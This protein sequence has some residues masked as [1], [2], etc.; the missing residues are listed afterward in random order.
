M[1]APL[2]EYCSGAVP[3]HRIN[4]NFF[5]GQAPG[6]GCGRHA[7]NNLLGQIYYV[8]NGQYIPGVHPIPLD[9]LCRALRTSMKSMNA[10][11]GEVWNAA[12]NAEGACQDNENYD[13]TVLIAGL[14]ILGFQ[15]EADRGRNVIDTDRTYGFLIN[16]TTRGYHWVALR[17]VGGGNYRYFDSLNGRHGLS[18]PAGEL[19]TL[20]NFKRTHP[21]YPVFLEV[22]KPEPRICIEPLRNYGI[23]QVVECPFHPGQEIRFEG[24]NYTVVN[25]HMNDAACDYLDVVRSEIYVPRLIAN[26]Q[27][28]FIE[29]DMFLAGTLLKM[30]I[31]GG[32]IVGFISRD[33]V[34]QELKARIG[35]KVASAFQ[36]KNKSGAS[37]KSYTNIIELER[38]VNAAIRGEGA[39]AN[40]NNNNA[41]LAA[42]I[43][44]SLQQTPLEQARAEAARAKAEAEAAEAAAIAAA[45]EA[46][47]RDL[48]RQLEELTRAKAAK[49]NAAAAAAA[50]ERNAAA[51]AAAAKRNAALVA[52]AAA[53]ASNSNA[54][55]A[56][57][58][59]LKIEEAKTAPPHPWIIKM[60]E[61]K[62]YPFYKNPLTG[63]TTWDNPALKRGGRRR[64]T[65][66]RQNKNKRN[67]T[68]K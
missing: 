66:R 14:N 32:R 22:I 48:E 3:E 40:A 11:K 1:A 59:A 5:E 6:A 29:I 61:T 2:T 35:E 37:K 13:Q 63:E 36:T 33:I 67:R 43:A 47:I 41:N 57:I 52:A 25:R 23:F 30:L 60:S 19:T 21:S 27:S 10:S 26:I 9:G 24:T 12:R 44:L 62:G 42:S 45:E 28:S 31:Q 54:R 38:R 15:V 58:R 49:R 4:P 34:L 18:Q 55:K 65:Q 68:R 20:E 51:V 17:K 8:K 46:E 56:I 16:T 39:G 50:A 7:L 53:T 64:I